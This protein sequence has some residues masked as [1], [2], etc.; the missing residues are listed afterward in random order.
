MLTRQDG[1]PLEFSLPHASSF[2]KPAPSFTK[3]APAI[4]QAVIEEAQMIMS[5]SSS[6][7][8]STST[9]SAASSSSS[10]S[11]SE[12]QVDDKLSELL[13]GLGVDIPTASQIRHSSTKAA[14]ERMFCLGGVERIVSDC[15]SKACLEFSATALLKLA[16]TDVSQLYIDHTYRLMD[17]GWFLLI[18]G[19][20][21]RRK[22]ACY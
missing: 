13:V 11:S 5:E 19:V 2:I 1:S 18:I 7:L 17:N 20:T 6:S 15:G 12:P 4:P 3:P 14:S 22:K 9:S 8:S 16:V 21:Q 10:L